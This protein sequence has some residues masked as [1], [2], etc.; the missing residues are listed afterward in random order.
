MVRNVSGTIVF[1]GFVLIFMGAVSPLMQVNDRSITNSLPIF[2][3]NG[4]YV[5]MSSPIKKR[6]VSLVPFTVGVG[7]GL[8]CIILASPVWLVA[9][10]LESR[11]RVEER[12]EVV[13]WQG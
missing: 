6:V 8:A 12:D 3:K 1:L 11:R 7:G 5:S 4:D 10:F 2:D 9:M 13:S